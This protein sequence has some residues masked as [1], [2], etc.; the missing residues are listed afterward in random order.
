MKS[1]RRQNDRFVVLTLLVQTLMWLAMTFYDYGFDERHLVDSGDIADCLGLVL[2][3]WLIALPVTAYFM[4]RK[5]YLRTEHPFRD[6]IIRILCWGALCF[7]ISLPIVWAVNTDVWI[8]KQEHSSG[9]FLNLNG[10]EY[11]YIPII[12]CFIPPL[13]IAINLVT[14]IAKRIYRA[15]KEK[16]KT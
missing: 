2:I 4:L 10:I 9:S 13:I 14:A 12:D 16:K 7:L 8:V 6:G 15:V 3:I 11:Y 1:S 5:K